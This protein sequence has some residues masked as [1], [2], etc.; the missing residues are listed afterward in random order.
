[1]TVEISSDRIAYVLTYDADVVRGETADLRCTNPSDLED[2]STREGFENDGNVVV[3][4]PVGY[5]GETEVVVTG[6]EGG[7]D[8]GTIQV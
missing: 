2:V 3:S 1:M 6:S 7:E 5:T 4:F 8:S